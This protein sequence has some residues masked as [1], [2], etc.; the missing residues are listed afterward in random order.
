[1]KILVAALSSATAADGVVRHASNVVR[2]LLERAEVQRVDLVI[3]S[4]QEP[5]FLELLKTIDPTL[6]AS[7]LYLHQARCAR[8]SLGRNLWYYRSLPALAKAF[9]SDVVH[10]TYPVPLARSRIACPVLVT[11]HDLYP[12]DLPENFG[13]PRVLLNRLILRQC[14]AAVDAIACVSKSTRERLL[15]RLPACAEKA[16]CI[17]N[18]V[19]PHYSEASPNPLVP[20]PFVLMVAQHRKNKDI[21]FALSIF[22]RLL[23]MEPALTL[24]VV[25]NEGPETPAI[26][27]M[28][29]DPLLQGKV[30]LLSGLSDAQLQGC[31]RHAALLLATSIV[32]GFGLPIAEAMLAGCPIVCSDIPAFRELAA[33][34]VHLIPLDASA[35]QSFLIAI[36]AVLADARP[37]PTA[38]PHFSISDI[39]ARYIQLYTHLL[40]AQEADT[41]SPLQLEQP[42][43]G[44]A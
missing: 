1:M 16:S 15:R 20:G 28:M 38:L 6:R 12:Y 40:T 2:C 37:Q 36:R 8:A 10:L 9:A 24:L 25:G 39:G 14:L 3:G 34:H 35:E 26:H 30:R 33:R 5:C 4:W 11:L 44:S 29:E 22:R 23:F 41:P 27:R 31:Y 42:K 21:L 19:I 18:C 17:Y 32:E 43:R 7:R 13:Y